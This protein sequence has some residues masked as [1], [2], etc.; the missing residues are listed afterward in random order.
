MRWIRLVV[1]VVGQLVSW[2]GFLA[3]VFDIPSPMQGKSAHGLVAFM[4]ST[5][6]VLALCVVGIIVTGPLLWTS[7]WWWPRLS[8]WSRRTRSD[9]E[10]REDE[11]P[12]VSTAIDARIKKFKELELLITRHRKAIAPIRHIVTEQLWNT[13]EILAFEADREV[14]IA[15]LDALRIPHPIG[16]AARPLWFNYL[17][18]LESACEIGGLEEARSLIESEYF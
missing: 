1:S 7:G 11:A 8:R 18:R 5:P 3:Y 17:V 15:E 12:V 13:S 14:L 4:T 10:T 6:V 2:G 16:A 9:R